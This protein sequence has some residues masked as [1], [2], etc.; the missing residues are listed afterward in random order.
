M[1]DPN[2]R[3]HPSAERRGRTGDHG[4]AVETRHCRS[5]RA[6]RGLVT[7]VL[8]LGAVVAPS[9]H[10]TASSSF[11]LVSDDFSSAVLDPSVWT[12]VDPVG[13]GTANVTNGQLHL[14]VPSTTDHDIWFNGNRSL[15]AVQ[16]VNDTDFDIEVKFSSPVTGNHQLQGIIIEHDADNFIRF[17]IH[18]GGGDT[19]AFIATFTNRTPTV[20]HHL[21][22]GPTGTTPHHL[23]VTRTGNQW[24][25]SW[26]T[27]GTN[28]TT[29][30]S[31]TH[32]LNVTAIGPFAGNAGSNPAHTAHIDHIIDRN[33]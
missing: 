19:N 10:A 3:S 27:N 20:R 8:L 13:D 11:G 17:D 24:T 16:H 2:E 12:V 5:K 29:P 1:S 6:R 28:W 9:S 18:S 22:V 30:S 26:S 32:D 33:Q 21:R 31:F 4:T 23:R 14:A 7:G 15:R 25:M